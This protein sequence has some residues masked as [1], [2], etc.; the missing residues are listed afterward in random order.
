MKYV[1]LFY[2]TWPLTND[3]KKLPWR[4]KG[5]SILCDSGDCLLICKS[6]R[7]H[8]SLIFPSNNTWEI[9]NMWVLIEALLP[10]FANDST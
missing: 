10:L 1:C 7:Y 3:Q 9:A 4:N 6:S 5:D 2:K 8:C